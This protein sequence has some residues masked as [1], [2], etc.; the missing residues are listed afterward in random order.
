LRFIGGGLGGFRGGLTEPCGLTELRQA[1]RA[2]V[3]G[4]G[5]GKRLAASFAW[6][7]VAHNLFGAEVESKVDGCVCMRAHL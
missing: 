6:A 7:R 3:V 1:S 2:D 5:S 4:R